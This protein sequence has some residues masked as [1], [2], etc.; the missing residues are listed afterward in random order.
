MTYRIAMVAACPFPVP[1]GSQVLLRQTAEGLAARGHEVHLVTYGYGCGGYDGPAILHR[2]P[3][4]VPVQTTA[5]GPNWAKPLL[6]AALVATLRRVVR[7]CRCDL[8]HAHN[9]EALVAGL[10]AGGAPV[11]YHAHNAL[12]DELPYYTRWRGPARRLGAWADR[13][14]PRRA[15]G[16]IAPH[17]RLKEY[18]LSCGCAP[19]QVAV[20]PPPADPG[21]LTL[22]IETGAAPAVLYAGNLDRYQNLPFLEEVMDRVRAVLPSVR[23]IIASHQPGNLARSGAGTL[24]RRTRGLSPLPFLEAEAVPVGDPGTLREVYAQDVVVAVPRVSWSGYPIKLV[25]AMAAGKA[26]VACAG[27]A[28]PLVD[29]LNGR[30][31][32]DNAAAAFAGALLDCLGD[33]GLRARLGK[34][35]RLTAQT[36][37][38]PE[39]IAAAIEDLYGRVLH[40]A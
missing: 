38:R 14:F 16:V 30:V 32:P 28:H 35:A 10:A 31:V 26:I 2:A 13:T 4:P 5:A 20:I 18:L 27:A 1:Q 24:G 8:I 29:G 25:N 37:H 12:G 23:F 21:L 9:Y 3:N 6:D 19:E 36:A 7:R 17:A 33:P 22:P 34:G 11:V 40:G 39:R 15:H